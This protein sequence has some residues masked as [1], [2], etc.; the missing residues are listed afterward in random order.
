MPNTPRSVFSWATLMLVSVLG[1]CT[2]PAPQAPSA[3]SATT[4]STSS[5]Q[6]PA[7]QTLSTEDIVAQRSKAYWQARI[8][9]NVEAAYALTPPSYRLAHSLEA[10]RL[11]HGVPPAFS[12][13]QTVRVECAAQR[14]VV[15]NSFKT[16]TPLA[17]TANLAVPKSDVW[18]QEQGDWWI[19]V[20]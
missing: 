6:G 2:A 20:E 4:S 8:G 19:F 3:A 5:T 11:K 18:V 1:A 14:C 7:V 16:F 10:F 12:D 9:S 13:P 17:P 15:T